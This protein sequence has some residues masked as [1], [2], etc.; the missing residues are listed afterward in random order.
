MKAGGCLTFK[1]SLEQVSLKTNYG[2][3][4]VTN[5]GASV[6]AIRIPDKN[7]VLENIVL[8]YDKISS[9]LCNPMYLGSTVGR[10]AGRIASG[11]F[12]MADR[13]VSLTKNEK[14]VNH[15]HGGFSGFSNKIFK[16]ENVSAGTDS[17]GVEFYYCSEDGEEGYPGK[18]ELRVK[19]VFVNNKLTI[20]YNAV[21]NAPTPLNLTNHCYFNL[22]GNK[23]KALQQQL[24][25]AA[26]NVLETDADY[27]PTG[28]LTP[29]KNSP[30]D[31]NDP[32]AISK[33]KSKLYSGVYNEYFVLDK[34]LGPAATIYDEDSGRKL[35]IDTNYPGIQF[36][37]GDYLENDFRPCE[38]IC[39]EAQHYPDAVNRP[40]FPPIIVKPGD[41]YQH[42]IS[43]SFSVQENGIQ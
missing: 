27:I 18:V 11:Q 26:S 10:V 5:A 23:N 14:S 31:F 17:A 42:F 30:H 4:V 38:G 37:S 33:D 25:I 2:E 19:Y 43:Y 16:T 20:F 35:K 34:S 24:F 7:G 9:Y 15:L 13:T 41:T 3:V 8:S 29:V 40:N 22:S 1:T 6:I 32:K 21:T 36:Y 12:K 28:Y 39:L